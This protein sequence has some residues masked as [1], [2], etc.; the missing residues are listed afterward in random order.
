MRIITTLLA[1][2]TLCPAVLAQQ[3]FELWPG[4]TSFFYRGA[5]GSSAGDLMQ[6]V[7]AEYHRGIG[8][9]GTDCR[10]LGLRGYLQDQNASTRETFTWIIRSGTD[11]AGPAGGTAGLI[12]SAGPLRTPQSS[13]VKA[14]LVT[15]IFATPAKLPDC[16][17]FFAFG[18][19]LPAAPNWT[20][21]LDGLSTWAARGDGQSVQ[22]A[23][24]RA[25]DHAWQLPPNG[26]TASHPW[27]KCTIRFKLLLGN[28]VLQVGQGNDVYGMGGM[29]PSAGNPLTVRARF[30]SGPGVSMLFLGTSRT[31]GFPLFAGTT[32]LYLGGLTLPLGTMV[33]DNSG[34]AVHTVVTSL[35]GTLAN[36]GTAY[37]QAAGVL[38]SNVSLTNAWSIKP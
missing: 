5:L 8:D 30:G 1:A 18:V 37:V 12:A 7:H 36:T 35:P 23:H 22:K 33:L 26:T 2:A 4:V 15:T 20:N 25:E 9:N 28:G 14:W 31:T 21:F 11:A 27:W 10:I 34:Q 24:S 6:G 38:T 13:G 17:S 32:Q 3:E 16:R 29:F 19:T